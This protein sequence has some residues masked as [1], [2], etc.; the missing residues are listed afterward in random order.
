MTQDEKRSANY[1]E[2]K[3]FI[4]TNYRNPSKHSDEERG[5]ISI[6]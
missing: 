2:L 6:E 3:N 1:N 5:Y 4:E